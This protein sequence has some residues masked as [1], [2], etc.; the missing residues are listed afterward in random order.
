MDEVFLPFFGELL[1]CGAI[2]SNLWMAKLE[3]GWK[4]SLKINFTII[5]WVFSHSHFYMRLIILSF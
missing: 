4:K 5:T 2:K 3:K 1:C